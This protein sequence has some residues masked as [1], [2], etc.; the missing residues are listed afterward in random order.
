MQQPLRRIF[1]QSKKTDCHREAE[2]KCI[3][4]EACVVGVKCLET[5]VCD[6]PLNVCVLLTSNTLLPLR[7]PPTCLLRCPPAADASTFNHGAHVPR[8]DEPL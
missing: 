3:F 7:Q 5:L 8:G 2:E 6:G 4:N 1:V